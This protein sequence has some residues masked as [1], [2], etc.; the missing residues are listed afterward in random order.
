MPTEKPL[1]KPG[2]LPTSKYLDGLR[3]FRA[4]KTLESG[5]GSK[6]R[7]LENIVRVRN[8]SRHGILHSR[9]R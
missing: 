5:A 9:M 7:N 6:D 3:R 1:N 4:S 8:V 2:M